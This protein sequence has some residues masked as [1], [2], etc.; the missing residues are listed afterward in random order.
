MKNDSFV[1][2][3]IKDDTSHAS[4]PEELLKAIQKALLCLGEGNTARATQ[5]LYQALPRDLKPVR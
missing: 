4:T 1:A 3:L 5:L 2:T